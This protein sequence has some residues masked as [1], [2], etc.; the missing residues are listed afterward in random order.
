M[1]ISTFVGKLCF[2]ILEKRA[3]FHDLLTFSSHPPLTP[4]KGASRPHRYWKT[5]RNFINIE[6]SLKKWPSRGRNES[7]PRTSKQEQTRQTTEQQELKS[8]AFSLKTVIMKGKSKH[9]QNTQTEKPKNGSKNRERLRKTEVASSG[10]MQY[11]WT[12]SGEATSKLWKNYIWQLG[13]TSE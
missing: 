9:K 6:K 11:T 13:L 2:S 5:G 12:N 8:S 1:E 7:L 10:C 4:Q 3:F